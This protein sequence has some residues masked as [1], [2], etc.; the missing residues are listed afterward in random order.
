MQTHETLLRLMNLPPQQFSGVVFSTGNYLASVHGNLG[1]N[2]FLG[3]PAPPH[4]GPGHDLMLK[5]W[6]SLTPAEQVAVYCLAANPIDG[7]PI[8]LHGHFGVPLPEGL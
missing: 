3:M 6:E 4:P 2:A 5:V 7:E 8:D 1:Y